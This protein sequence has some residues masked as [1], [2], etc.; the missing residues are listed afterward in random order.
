MDVTHHSECRRECCSQ[1]LFKD[2]LWGQARVWSVGYGLTT[3]AVGIAE[4]VVNEV[5]VDEQAT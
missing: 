5:P 3:H 4:H 1:A 2:R